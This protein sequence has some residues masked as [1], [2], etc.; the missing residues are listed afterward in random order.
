MKR[1]ADSKTGASGRAEKNRR[2]IKVRVFRFGTLL[3]SA[4]NG[5]ESRAVQPDRVQS[6]IGWIRS[7]QD[8]KACKMY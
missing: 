8:R 3:T 1:I 6:M 5:F 7:M 4:V 2:P